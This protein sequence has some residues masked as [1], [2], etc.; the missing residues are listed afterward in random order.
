MSDPP[1][2][3]IDFKSNMTRVWTTLKYRLWLGL[4]RCDEM[5]ELRSENFRFDRKYRTF[6]Q[7]SYPTFRDFGHFHRFLS[8]QNSEKSLC[9]M[10]NF[11]ES[12]FWHIRHPIRSG[13]RI[14]FFWICQFW[15]EPRSQLIFQNRIWK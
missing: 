14:F 12:V 4:V 15:A 11:S 10:A 8:V 9:W 3:D 1:L 5:S 2:S 6:N 7:G 13:F